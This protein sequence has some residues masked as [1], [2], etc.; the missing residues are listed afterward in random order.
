M[1][2]L[3]K[4]KPGLYTLT[5]CI[6]VLCKNNFLSFTHTFYTCTV[7]LPHWWVW[8]LGLPSLC[9]DDQ[10]HLCSAGWLWHPSC[11]KPVVLSRRADRIQYEV[12]TVRRETEEAVKLS[13]MEATEC[14]K[15]RSIVYDNT[16]LYQHSCGDDLH[17]SDF[18]PLTWRA[19]HQVEQSCC[20]TLTCPSPS[21]TWL[22]TISMGREINF[23]ASCTETVQDKEMVELI[24][25][26]KCEAI[27]P[28]WRACWYSCCGQCHESQTG[29]WMSRT[30]CPS[31]WPP[32]ICSVDENQK[33]RRHVLLEIHFI[34]PYCL[35]L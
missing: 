7:S 11:R 20:C 17:C 14:W 1:D 5:F 10:L 12:I 28:R 26:N 22:C 13:T 3:C 8:Q 32:Y 25:L 27:V 18:W 21:Q 6:F 24:L 9:Q 33:F 35:N 29:S 34:V 2:L 16:M 30:A 31:Y 23:K 19:E 4:W 15:L